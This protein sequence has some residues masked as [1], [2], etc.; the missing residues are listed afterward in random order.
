MTHV[1]VL[2]PFDGFAL[3]ECRLE[4]GRTHQVRIHLGEAGIP[5]CG[6]RVYDR[7]PHGSPLPDNSGATRPMLHAARLEFVVRVSQPARLRFGTARNPDMWSTFLEYWTRFIVRVDGRVVF[8]RTLDPRRNAA[9]RRWIW[10]DVPV[11]EAGEH[12]IAFEMST[13]SRHG[14][15]ANLGGWARARLVADEAPPDA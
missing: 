15:K 5:L 3:V 8:D 2:E 9:D 4:T 10:S 6:E 1:R 7:A 14:V 11:P 12:A 13:E